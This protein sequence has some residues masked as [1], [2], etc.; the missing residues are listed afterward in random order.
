MSMGLFRL[1][2]AIGKTQ[3]MANTLGTA[4]LIAIYILAGFV[5]SRGQ[6]IVNSQD[7]IELAYTI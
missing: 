7:T 2:A 6:I 1:I 4:A 3:M 5:I